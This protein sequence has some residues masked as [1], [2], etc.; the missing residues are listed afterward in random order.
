VTTDYNLDDPEIGLGGFAD[1]STQKIHLLLEVAQVRDPGEAKATLIHEA[2]HLSNSSVDDQVYYGS[3]GFF[4]ADEAKK[5]ANAA[6]YEELP[7]RQMSIS[8]YAAKTFMP[9][10]MPSGAPAT[11]QDRVRALANLYL[12]HAWDAAVDAHTFIREV[13]R[14]HLAGDDRPFHRHRALIMEMS[15][16]MD[17]TIHTQAPAHRMV[18]TLDVTLS[19]SVAH[20]VGEIGTIADGLPFP[21]AGALT[22]TQLRDLIVKGAIIKYGALF[23]DPA[24]A[25][26]VVDWCAAHYRSLPTL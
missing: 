20:G 4:E 23:R 8:R 24:R 2:A 16:V 6:H 11:R 12:R 19:E 22:D 14:Q 17:L 18:T 26:A 21:A 15:R 13:R 1:F 10:V 9:G 5:V 3:P 25:R 7:R